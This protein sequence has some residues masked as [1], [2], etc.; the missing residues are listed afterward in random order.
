MGVRPVWVY[1]IENKERERQLEA[2]RNE[3]PPPPLNV[4]GRDPKAYPEPMVNKR[5]VKRIVNK[6]WR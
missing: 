2:I 1:A 4:R 5:I 3:S 6:I